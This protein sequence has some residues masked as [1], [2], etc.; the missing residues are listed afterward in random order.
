MT[1]L[2]RKCGDYETMQAPHIL[3][4]NLQFMRQKCGIFEKM[5]PLHKYADFG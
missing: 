4:E 3:H 1:F 5:W 2:P